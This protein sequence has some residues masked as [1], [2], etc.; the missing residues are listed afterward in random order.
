MAITNI[1]IVGLG[2]M[3]LGMAATLARKGF[4][5]KGYDISEARKGD[6]GSEGCRLLRGP[7]RRTE[8]C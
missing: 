2:N 5:V 6:R 4:K 8:Q 1:G 7:D 3:G